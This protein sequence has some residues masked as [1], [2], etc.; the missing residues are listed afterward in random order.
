M[1]RLC[2]GWLAITLLP[3]EIDDLLFAATDLAHAAQ[4][5]DDQ[6]IWAALERWE[7]VRYPRGEEAS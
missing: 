7:T 5:R 3:V 2:L 4:T 6:L 1:L